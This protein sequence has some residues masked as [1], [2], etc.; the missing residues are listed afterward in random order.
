[1]ARTKS[2]PVVLDPADREML[3]ALVRTGSH[4]ALQVRRARILF[5]AVLAVATFVAV[6]QLVGLVCDLTPDRLP[7]ESFP[8]HGPA[9][10]DEAG[11]VALSVAAVSSSLRR[12]RAL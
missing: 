1:M 9:L 10:L 2:R 6:A 11:G 4:P 5:L 8:T 7:F 3:T 12:L